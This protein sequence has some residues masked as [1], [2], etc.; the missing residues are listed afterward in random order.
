MDT[1]KK[2]LD[3]LGKQ[4]EALKEAISSDKPEAAKAELDK[5]G[6]MKTSSHKELGVG[7]DSPKK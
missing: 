3:E 7:Q 6:K 2:N 1:Y 5:I 4:L